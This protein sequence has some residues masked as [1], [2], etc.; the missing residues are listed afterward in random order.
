MSCGSNLK[1]EG[2]NIE[3]YINDDVVPD[4]PFKN[5]YHEFVLKRLIRMAA[6]QGYDGW[7]PSDSKMEPEVN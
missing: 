5:N 7:T 3:D 6:E 2:I 4:A 1:M